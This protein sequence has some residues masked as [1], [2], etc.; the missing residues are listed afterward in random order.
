MGSMLRNIWN[1]IKKLNRNQV[2]L[3]FGLA[4]TQGPNVKFAADWMGS[5]GIP[6]LSKFVAFL[7]WLSTALSSVALAWPSI[8]PKLAAFG[9]ATPPGALAPWI[10]GKPGDPNATS[11]DV[12]GRVLPMQT[13]TPVTRPETPYSKDTP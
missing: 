13:P 1:V 7:G 10:P 4:V 2:M 12:P 6:H 9:L 3:L 5:L 8:R 11:G